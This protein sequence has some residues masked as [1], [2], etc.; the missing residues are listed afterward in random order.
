MMFLE[1]RWFEESSHRQSFKF[2]LAFL[3]VLSFFNYLLVDQVNCS[4]KSGNIYL[5]LKPN[6]YERTL[7]LLVLPFQKR[8]FIIIILVRNLH[9]LRP[10]VLWQTL[11]NCFNNFNI[12]LCPVK[13]ELFLILWL[14]VKRVLNFLKDLSCSLGFCQCF[15]YF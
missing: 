15:V 12:S 14:L 3:V 13:H 11:I 10:F 2:H 5:T 8:K 6:K 7:L 9:I 1:S 4:Q